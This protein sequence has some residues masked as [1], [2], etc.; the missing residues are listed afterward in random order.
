[1]LIYGVYG[2]TGELVLAEALRRGMRPILAGRNAPALERLAERHDL[3]FRAFSLDEPRTVASA[4]RGAGAVLHCAGPFVHT[5]RAMVDACLATGVHYLDITGEIA[6]FEAILVRGKEARSACVVLLPGVGFDVVPTDC[7][8]LRLKERLPDATHLE[9]AFV[10]EGGRM[11]RGT[12]RTRIASLPLA[13][14]ERVDGEIRPTGLAERTREIDLPAGRRLVVSIPWGDVATA[15]HT[16]GIPNVRV[17]TGIP[18][19][20]LARMRRWRF[21]LPLTRLGAVRRM[22]LRRVDR[23]PPGPDEAT[24]RTARIQIWGEARNAAGRFVRSTFSMPE[25]YAFT[26]LSAVE[27]LSRVV[28]GEVAPG[29][30][31]P[32]RAFGARF[33]FG[34]DGVDPA[35]DEDGSV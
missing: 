31:T 26:A 7:L 12:Q 16:T 29:A 17:S 13:G 30:W 34:C 35:V 25:G 11:S 27:A 33:V 32:A 6:V 8:A 2:Y 21:L 24:R 3:P 10:A 23:Q 14:A 15:F 22:L 28:A 19:R 1:M 4:V 20:A 5:S 18:P 9:L